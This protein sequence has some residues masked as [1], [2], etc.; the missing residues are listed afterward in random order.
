MSNYTTEVRFIC[1]HE[2]GLTES[3]GYKRV[4]DILKSVHD[5]VFDFYYPIFDE[6]YRETLECNILRHYYTREICAE[7]VGLWKLWLDAR[8]NEIMPYY[9]KMY[10]SEL[11]KFNPLHDV[12]FTRTGNKS[13][14]G[15]QTN[16]GSVVGTGNKAK[17][18]TI[19]DDGE[20]TKRGTVGEEEDLDKTGT[21]SD[22]GDKTKTGTVTDDA[23]TANTGTTTNVKSGSETTQGQSAPKNNRWDLYSD[24]PQGGINGIEQATDS[25]VD[26]AYLTNARHIIEDGTGSTSGSTLTFNNVTNQQTDNTQTD[27]DNETTYDTAE[28]DDNV[29]TYD[30][31]D[32]KEKETTYNTNDTKDNVRTFNTNDATTEQKQTSGRIKDDSLTEYLETI[33]GKRSF[34]SYSTLLKQYRETFLN[35]D[36]MII[37]ELGDLF[38]G[39]WE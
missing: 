22:D 2:Y 15:T 29:R 12:D 5:K 25:L 4:D 33:V 38:F 32:H 36:K 13:V 34:T 28:T 11:L 27:Y 6:N 9:N 17:T 3:V 23:T 8:M 20:S 31:N 24:T 18:G 1:E 16:T 19:T 35:I 37:E 39:L 26:N 21:I 14:D 30:T 7:T 10:E